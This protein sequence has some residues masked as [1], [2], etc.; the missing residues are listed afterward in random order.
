MPV[1]TGV[2]TNAQFTPPARQDK[3]VL[4]VYQVVR[5]ESARQ[6][7]PVVAL[8]RPTHSDTERTC[9]AVEP[10]QFTP[11]HQTRQNSPVCVVSGV[12]V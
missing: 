2:V 3:T 1:Y 9:L 10:T 7:R 8:R 11:P 4:S 6:V 5:I 12:A